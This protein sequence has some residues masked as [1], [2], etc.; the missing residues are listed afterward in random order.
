MGVTVFFLVFFLFEL[1]S[2]GDIWRNVILSLGLVM[3]SWEVCV[4][5]FS[6]NYEF[7][8]G[9]CIYAARE[10]FHFFKMQEEK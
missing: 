6:Q 9:S 3:P 2:I 8:F 5:V 7:Y 1:L 10:I 4:C